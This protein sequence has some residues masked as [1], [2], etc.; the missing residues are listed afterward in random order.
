[1]PSGTV[2]VTAPAEVAGWELDEQQHEGL[3][4]F[5]GSVSRWKLMAWVF[6]RP[7]GQ[8]F[9]SR[10]IQDDGGYYSGNWSNNINALVKLGMVEVSRRQSYSAIFYKRTESPLWAVVPAI[11]R[12]LKQPVV[13]P[14]DLIDVTEDAML[15][16]RATLLAAELELQGDE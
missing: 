13:L 1:M 16:A 9:T 7:A 11:L 4:A 8:E 14:A 6:T 12:W 2:V 10:T 3:R 5:I 15:N